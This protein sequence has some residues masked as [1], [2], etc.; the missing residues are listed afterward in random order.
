MR[1]DF[2]KFVVRIAVFIALLFC[3]DRIVAIIEDKV[4]S[5]TDT[6]LN[7]AAYCHNDDEI[8]ILGSS[9]AA[10]HYIPA[11][12]SDTTKMS[13]VNLGVD[14]Q[15]IYYHYALLNLLLTNNSP[16]I[17]IY[18]LLDIDFLNTEDKY[19]TSRLDAL[20]PVFG[21]QSKV[22]SLI[23]LKKG[24]E[25]QI[26]LFHSYR[27]NSKVHIIIR[28]SY[29]MSNNGYV[30]IYGRWNGWPKGEEDLD[31]SFDDNKLNCLFR[32]IDLCHNNGIRIIVAVSP[33]YLTEN[34]DRD[35]YMQVGH[36]CEEH[37][38][39]FLYREYAINKANLFK[40]IMHMNDSGAQMYSSQ[41]AHELKEY[42]L[43]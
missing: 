40:D 37:N 11:I 14:G 30:P 5:R 1:R 16:K 27:Y 4:Y 18:E 41:I 31:L 38:A 42:F 2:T 10:H 15:N 26:K 17:V 22:D 35:Y 12:I 20:S 39:I 7:Y 25:K 43:Q 6:K 28:N 34:A 24:Y 3:C 36:K 32:L 9:R 13:C 33:T 29:P 19:T 21:Q 8:V 23:L